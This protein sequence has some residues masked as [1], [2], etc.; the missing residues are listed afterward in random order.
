M[1]VL[2]EQV[3]ALLHVRLG[4]TVLVTLLAVALVFPMQ[5]V[6]ELNQYQDYMSIAESLL[7]DYSAE[8]IAA[9][10]L[11]LMQEGPKAL[12]AQVEETIST[13]LQNT[14]GKPGMVR[15]F[16]NIGRAQKITVKDIISAIAIEADIPARSIGQI[17]IYEK[18]T[19]VEVPEEYAEQVITALHRNYIKGY[20]INVEPAKLKR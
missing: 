2:V 7:D 12:Q 16:L 5:T 14:G 18:F 13:D 20:K 15:M 6:L 8:D 1:L 9:A 10:A 19:F 17:S 3:I 4:V 11:K